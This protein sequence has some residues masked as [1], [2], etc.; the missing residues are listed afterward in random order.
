MFVPPCYSFSVFLSGVYLLYYVSDLPRLLLVPP[1]VPPVLHTPPLP[2]T[3]T[4]PPTQSILGE[5]QRRREVFSS[6]IYN[7]KRKAKNEMARF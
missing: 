6:F 4:P 1:G 3:P 7:I 5:G 2:H